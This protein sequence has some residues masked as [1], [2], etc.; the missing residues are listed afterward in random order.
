PETSELSVTENGVTFGF[1][2]VSGQKTGW[3]FDHRNNRA[4]LNALIAQLDAPRV[5][6]VFSYVGGWGVQALAAGAAQVDFVD[7]SGEVLEWASRNADTQAGDYQCLQGNAF[8]VLKA[9]CEDKARYDVVILDP[10]AL[11]PRRKD[12]RSGEQAYRRLNQL[13]M[14]LVQQGGWL[15][16][17]SC[18]M[19]LGRDRLTD[20][21]RA[22][23]REVDRDARL[24]WEGHQGED[25]PILPAVPE[26]AYLKAQLYQVEAVG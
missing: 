18:S 1:D 13:A 10:P 26:T 24:V 21:V 16:S 19:H 2:V 9:L 11:I 25:H 8:E 6:D 22:A 23:S 14:R 5:L 4:R 17:A 20:L 12:I 3:F 7:A 15:M